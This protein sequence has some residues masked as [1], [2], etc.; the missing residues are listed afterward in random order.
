M[1][2]KSRLNIFSVFCP[3][4]ES[5][6]VSGYWSFL[7]C[8][9]YFF[10]PPRH[11]LSRK[12]EHVPECSLHFGQ[13]RVSPRPTSKLRPADSPTLDER[14]WFSAPI[15]D[16]QTSLMFFLNFSHFRFI[17]FNGAKV[18]WCRPDA[19]QST[20]ACARVILTLRHFGPIKWMALNRR[21][22]KISAPSFCTEGHFF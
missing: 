2:F 17:E 6:V 21:F 16:G 10:S 20:N 3:I 15:G 18:R 5:L 9:I 13:W 19:L 8:K 7:G 1:Y 12:R 14:M 11:G 4:L 22:F